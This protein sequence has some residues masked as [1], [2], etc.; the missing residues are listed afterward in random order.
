MIRCELSVSW[1]TLLYLCFQTME[2]SREPKDQDFPS[3]FQNSC[4][5]SSAVESGETEE[6]M[7]KSM[8]SGV[9]PKSQTVIGGITCCVPEC[10]RNRLRNPE[11]S[12]YVIP[13]GKGKEKQ[14]LRGP[15]HEKF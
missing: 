10:F 3:F 4:P 15:L 11:L 7:K 6:V 12:F 5:G 14:G 9:R 13:S 8:D 1:L 2:N